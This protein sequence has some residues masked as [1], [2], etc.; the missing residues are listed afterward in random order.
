MQ[1]VLPVLPTTTNNREFVRLLYQSL[2][3]K[4]LNV[5][6]ALHGKLQG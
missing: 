6:Y 5:F 3:C 2:Y 1:M 4:H